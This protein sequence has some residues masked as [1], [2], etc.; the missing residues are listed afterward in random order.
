MAQLEKCFEVVIPL[1]LFTF[2]QVGWKSCGL[3]EIGYAFVNITW[4]FYMSL[5][6]YLYF[7][8]LLYRNVSICMECLGDCLS[9]WLLCSVW[10]IAASPCPRVNHRQLDTAQGCWGHGEDGVTTGDDDSLIGKLPEMT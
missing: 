7:S 8:I 2:W 1:G 9:F 10:F 4:F 5:I 3:G 6:Q